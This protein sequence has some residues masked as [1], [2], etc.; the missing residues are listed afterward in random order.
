MS[1]TN[2]TTANCEILN[3]GDFEL[4]SGATIRDC[5]LAY[6]VYGSLN[7]KRDNAIVVPTF[8]G[9]NHEELETIIGENKP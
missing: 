3:I 1:A 7:K 8:Y 4:Q 2:E 5:K 9:G 6:K